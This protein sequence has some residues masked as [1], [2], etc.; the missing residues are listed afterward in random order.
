[1]K[2]LGWIAAA[3][4]VALIATPVQAAPVT[5]FAAASLKNALDEVG[6]QYARSGGQ[7]RFSYAGSSAIARQIEQGAPADV[8]VSADAEWM[9]YLAA[10]KLIVNATRRDLL[11]NRLA[12]IAPADSKVALKIG[13]G[14]PLARTLRD[15]R[16]AVAGPDV[17][18]GKYAKASLST[19]GVWDSASGRLAQAEN[20]RMALQYVARGESPLGIVYDT[21]AKVEP[22]V[23]I[24]G[25][26]PAGTHP[27]IVYPAAVVAASNNP[28]AA[29]F[30]AFLNG[31][32]AAAIFRKYGFT[33][34]PRR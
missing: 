2:A 23:R 8:Y 14:M 19:L 28:G 24:V 7:A 11:T 3:L 34:L 31:P 27:K 30:M 22:K 1:M 5:V 10:R 20:V 21:D 33:V 26:F 16:L 6:A 32:Q 12:L 17:P 18:A 25:L 29:K 15:R 9:D 13:R 4:A